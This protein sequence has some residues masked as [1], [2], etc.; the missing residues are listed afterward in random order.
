MSVV[1]VGL[2]HRTVPLDLFERMTVAESLL[3]KALADLTSREH[4][5]EAVAFRCALIRA[6][7]TPLV[8]D[9]VFA[10]LMLQLGLN[11]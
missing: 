10:D 1:V 9:C 3:P 8:G 11:V 6:L 7:T 2:N 5:T 4:I